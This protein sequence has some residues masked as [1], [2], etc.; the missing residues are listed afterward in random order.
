ML[1]GYVTRMAND[2]PTLRSQSNL[3]YFQFFVSHFSEEEIVVIS[4]SIQ[5]VFIGAKFVE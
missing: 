5:N 4:V 3:Q 2:L 1:K